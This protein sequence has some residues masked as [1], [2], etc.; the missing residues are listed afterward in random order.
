MNLR[1]PLLLTFLSLTLLLGSCG[2]ND[3][4]APFT[5]SNNIKGTWQLV[6]RYTSSGGP[7]Q[8]SSVT[9]GYTYTFSED[10]VVITDQFECDGTY[11]FNAGRLTID[12]NCPDQQFNHTYKIE[13][14]GNFIILSP[15]PSPCDEGCAEKFR[16]ITID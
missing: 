6:E 2:K 12:F 15:D 5:D 4:D 9:N 3:I 13:S 16:R 8:W 10:N 1:F 11:Q 14:E 7:G